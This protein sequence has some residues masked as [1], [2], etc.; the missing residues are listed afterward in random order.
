MNSSGRIDAKNRMSQSKAKL[1]GCPRMGGI[2]AII[3]ILNAR[4]KIRII[5][6]EHALR[7]RNAGKDDK[8]R[9]FGLH[10]KGGPCGK[11]CPSDRKEP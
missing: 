5:G 11:A 1:Q 6:F 8:R 4:P 10:L 2:D 9:C 7:Q 3:L